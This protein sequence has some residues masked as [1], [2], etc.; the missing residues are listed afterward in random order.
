V[1]APQAIQQASIV[2]GT[3]AKPTPI[4]RPRLSI[5]LID[6][7]P[8]VRAGLQCIL[9]RHSDLG[10]SA[11]AGDA[12]T[13]V[14]EAERTRPHVVVMDMTVAGMNAIDATR[15][16]RA[17]LP[18][19]GVVLLSAHPS[20][21]V[22][23]RAL[24]AG[25]LG[26]LTRDI[27]AEELVRAVRAAAS[28]EQYI[29]P[30]LAHSWLETRRPSER[31]EPA[32]EVLTGTE[33]KILKLVTEGRSNAEVAATISLSPRTVETYRVRLMRKLGID[34]LPSLVRYAIRHGI[35]PLE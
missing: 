6:P 14:R 20:P 13:A 3:K 23:R 28:G 21:P 24:E 7:H 15:V 2:P 27:G 5:L 30:Q 16:L 26:F 11:A 1:A 8:I 33:Q 10:V 22:V 9:E 35:I 17:K 31:P 4:R 25:A 34:N 19:I 18:G 12:H 32:I 29:S